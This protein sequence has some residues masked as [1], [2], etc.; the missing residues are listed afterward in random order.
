MLQFV[1]VPLRGAFHGGVR[2]ACCALLV[3]FG[4]G[5]A[6]F[7]AP[8]VEIREPSSVRA[9]QPPSPAMAAAVRQ[10]PVVANG[11]I[12]Q[13]GHYRPLFEDRRARMVG[14]VLTIQLQE[15]TSA[16]QSST[17][18][19]DRSGS[20]KGAIGALPFLSASR[21]SKLGAEGSS[22]NAFEGKGETGSDNLFT[23]TITVTVIEVLPN[24]NMVV[25]GE[26]QVGVNQNVD[27]LRFSGVVSPTTVQPSNTVLSTSVAD[28]RVEFRGRG[29]IDRAQTVG[30][31]TRFFLSFLPI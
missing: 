9:D 7:G 2:A 30:W 25:S 26:K 24:G 31:L 19:I 12:Y 21:L 20:T 11:S 6:M 4:S 18:T 1:A 29:D 28:A 17:S 13:V 22:S 10:S 14:D 23:G 8:R 16:R 27:V 3:T 15:K 5:C